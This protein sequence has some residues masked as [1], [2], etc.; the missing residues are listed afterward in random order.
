MYNERIMQKFYFQAV[1]TE[2]KQI[3]GYI[4]A[5]SESLAHQKLKTAG[6]SVLTL[7]S[8]DNAVHKEGVQVFDFAGINEFRKNV[9]G[10]IEAV[11]KY[12]AY[13]K[14]RIEYKID[15][16]YIIPNGLEEVQKKLLRV[17]GVEEEL[18]KRLE[19]ELKKELKKEDSKE[20]E[21]EDEI[22]SVL[23]SR[24]KEIDFMHDKIEVVL[25]EVIPLLKENEDYISSTKKRE[26]EE[27]INL[28][29]R[30]KHSNSVDHLK[31]LT[32]NLLIQLTDDSL[33]LEGADLSEDVKEDIQ[34]RKSQFV[35]LG[36]NFDKI[37]TKGLSDL[38]INVGGFD[39]KKL[40][41]TVIKLN[42]LDKIMT[43]F[44][45]SF[46][47]LF[48]FFVFFWIWNGIQYYLQKDI[49]R[50]NFYFNSSLMNYITVFSFIIILTF[51]FRFRKKNSLFTKLS[52]VGFGIVTLF[53]V[54][55]EF[56]VIFYWIP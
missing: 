52:F 46:V 37:I 48:S 45:F 33:F 35:K 2:G 44:Y 4:S 24:E 55:L 3:S 13:K 38:K 5:E 7:E 32:K 40:K 12:S 15:L 42:P 6:M 28:L 22:D 54:T 31:R 41:E 29:S 49:S 21:K 26:I 14:L 19:I 27:R 43:V 8:R 51:S 39:T 9:R 20:E 17:Q 16:K 34:R 56:P 47:F 25:N 50:V 36:K 1:T 11:D 30:L 10:T 53:L 18:E 23:K